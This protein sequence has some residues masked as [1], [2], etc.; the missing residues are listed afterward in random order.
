MRE[1]HNTLGRSATGKENMFVVKLQI[2]LIKTSYSF[3]EGRTNLEVLGV[4]ERIIL[5]W[6]LRKFLAMA[7][8]GLIWLGLGE[9]SVCCEQGNEHSF[10]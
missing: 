7:R 2:K 9:V 6:I 5:K 1:P 10:G 8:A 4:D 3:F